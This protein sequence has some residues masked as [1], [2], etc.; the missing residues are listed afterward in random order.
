MSCACLQE[1]LLSKPMESVLVHKN[2]K[3]IYKNNI[4]FLLY[5]PERKSKEEEKPLPKIILF[6]PYIKEIKACKRCY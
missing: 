2:N 5:T 3:K 4:L 6:K 1:V